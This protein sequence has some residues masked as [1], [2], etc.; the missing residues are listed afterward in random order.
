MG[1]CTASL[2]LGVNQHIL[3]V[4]IMIGF[5]CFLMIWYYQQNHLKDG[6][7]VLRYHNI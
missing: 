5:L 3:F 1:R 6:V 2:S 7:V 4:H